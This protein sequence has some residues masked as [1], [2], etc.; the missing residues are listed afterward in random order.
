MTMLRTRYV[1]AASSLSRVAER[2]GLLLDERDRAD[3]VVGDGRVGLLG[4]DP[5]DDHP[6]EVAGDR[7]G[8]AAAVD[9]RQEV[10]PDPADDAILRGRAGAGEGVVDGEQQLLAVFLRERVLDRLGVPLR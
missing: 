4:L 1:I 5:V 3:A 9:A 8:A 2:R 6:G 10:E 7:A